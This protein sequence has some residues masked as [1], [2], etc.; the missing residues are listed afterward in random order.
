MSKRK[1]LNKIPDKIDILP[2]LSKK[3]NLIYCNKIKDI[4]PDKI[5]YT[6]FD[7]LAEMIREC[8]DQICIPFITKYHNLTFAEFDLDIALN[9]TNKDKEVLIPYFELFFPKEYECP[10][11]DEYKHVYVLCFAKDKDFESTID[12]FMFYINKFK[13]LKV[14][15]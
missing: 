3:F 5:S 8:G 14:F 4:L 1:K 11:G 15:I 2:E 9:K 7:N 13:K 12:C 6:F 10:H